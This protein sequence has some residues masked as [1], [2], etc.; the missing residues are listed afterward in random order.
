[1]TCPNCGPVAKLSRQKTALIGQQA[2]Q[3]RRRDARIGELEQKLAA[4]Q[5]S[6]DT[7]VA[8]YRALLAEDAFIP[9]EILREVSNG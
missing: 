3:I 7:V 5:R 1:M 9:E 6:L 2:D 8:E 4:L